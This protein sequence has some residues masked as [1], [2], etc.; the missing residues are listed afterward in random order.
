MPPEIYQYSHFG[1]FLT[2]YVNYRKEERPGFSLRNLAKRVN[3]SPSLIAMISRGE[4]IPAPDLTSEI[5]DALKLKAAETKY[6]VALNN[7]H[8]AKTPAAKRKHAELLRILKP[9]SSDLQLDLD[10]FE[11]MSRWYHIVILE[12]ISLQGFKE[13]RKAIADELGSSVTTKMV[14]DSIE[15]LIRLGIVTRTKNGKLKRRPNKVLIPKT[16][17][18]AAIRSFHKEVLLRAHQAIER[19]SMKERYF[20]TATVAVPEHLIPEISEKIANF[21]DELISFITE[22]NDSKDSRIYHL[23]FQ[24]F[25]STK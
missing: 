12:M 8:R 15:L 6:A 7:Y 13:D 20:S 14:K 10:S 25:R 16:V 21:R 18:S 23:G 5:C 19:Q 9:K 4:R 17:P 1:P 24:F 3:R 22:N 11:M 2:D